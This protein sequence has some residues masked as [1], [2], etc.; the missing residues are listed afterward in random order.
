MEDRETLVFGFV[1]DVYVLLL[2]GDRVDEQDWQL[3]ID[4]ALF[5]PRM[6]RLLL[7][8]RSIVPDVGQ[9]YDLGR[10]HEK[11]RIKA[12][13]VSDAPTIRRVV[14]A[15]KWSGME[16]EGFRMDELDAMLAFLGCPSL[17]ARISSA[18][19]P[20]LDRSWLHEVAA[21][22]PVAVKARPTAAHRGIA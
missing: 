5:A 22:S 12:A 10:L 17:R 19:G 2:R 1:D 7:V 20:Y 14:T 21:S 4:E 11:H 18:L 3:A 15:L 9:R 6:T 16:A 8:A 13:L